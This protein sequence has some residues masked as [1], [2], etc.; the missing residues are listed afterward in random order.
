MFSWRNKKNI[1]TFGLKKAPYQELCS[2]E[3]HNICFCGP[4]RKILCGYLLL[5][6]G[7]RLQAALSLCWARVRRYIYLHC[8]S[9]IVVL[10]R[11]TDHYMKFHENLMKTIE[12]VPIINMI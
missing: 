3:A 8:D 2:I 10:I 7:I 1:N 12:I 4:I 9:H 6:G 5:S 11:S